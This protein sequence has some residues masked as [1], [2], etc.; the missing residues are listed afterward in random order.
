[1]SRPT[2]TT[3][4][5]RASLVPLL[6]FTLV[7]AACG[8]DGDDTAAEAESGENGLPACEQTDIMHTQPVHSL[9]YA[10]VY[11][12]RTEGF[13][14]DVGLEVEQVNTGGGGPDLQALIAGEAQF[15]SGGGTYQIDALREGQ[16]VLTVYNYRDREIV[17]VTLSHEAAEAAGVDEDSSLDERIEALRG[18]TIGATRPGALT[19]HIARAIVRSAGMDPDNDVEIIGA[20]SGAE[21]IAALAQGQVDSILVTQPQ[22]YQAVHEG[23]GI[24]LISNSRGEIPEL[25]PFS[26]GNIYTTSS[27]ADENPGCVER[28][29]SAIHE[30]NQWFLD[31]DVETVADSLAEE[32][33]DFD[34]EVLSY[35]IELV[36]EAGNAS[37]ELDPAAVENVIWAV[38]EQEITV[39]DVMEF[40][41]EEFIPEG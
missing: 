31:N 35:S 33:A 14:E 8:D 38:D 9:G 3:P 26:G 20:G 29:V 39:D 36:Q 30:A 10:P 37:G 15:N 32:F 6:A 1:M 41:T 11:I 27:F 13:F 7:L 34:P 40:Y 23:H 24:E 12:A 17:D 28:Y 25:D 18:T 16:E 19:Y 4:R 22:P 5:V 21:I 2:S